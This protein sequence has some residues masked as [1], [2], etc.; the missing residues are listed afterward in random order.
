VTRV[1]AHHQHIR[2]HRRRLH[3]RPGEHPRVPAPRR[4]LHRYRR[5]L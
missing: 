4:H 5:A 1:P 3:R 2:W